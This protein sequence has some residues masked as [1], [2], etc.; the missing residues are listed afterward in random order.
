MSRP[1]HPVLECGA[2]VARNKDCPTY[3]GP[4][5]HEGRYTK[6]WRT[7]DMPDTSR[8]FR[9]EINEVE[10]L[11][12]QWRGVGSAVV[13]HMLKGGRAGSAITYKLSYTL[14]RSGQK[15]SGLRLRTGRAV[16]AAAP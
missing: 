15:S 1:I 6:L 16:E 2:A 12:P 10:E 3:W 13:S 8:W 7:A 11:P 4:A 14:G 5:V 9:G